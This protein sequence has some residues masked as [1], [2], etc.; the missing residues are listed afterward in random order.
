MP[1]WETI[2]AIGLGGGV[3]SQPTSKAA[4]PRAIF[5]IFTFVQNGVTHGCLMETARP[6]TRSAWQRLLGQLWTEPRERGR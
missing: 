6:S 4:L 2:G 1:A 5:H 3:E